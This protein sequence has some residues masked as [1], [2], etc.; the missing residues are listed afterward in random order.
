MIIIPSP[1]SLIPPTRARTGI[2]TK[3]SVLALREVG[4]AAAAAVALRTSVMEVVTAVMIQRQSQRWR[5]H[6]SAVVLRRRQ[7][8]RDREGR[9]QHADDRGS[10]SRLAGPSGVPPCSEGDARVS[11]LGTLATRVLAA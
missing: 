6:L 7:W 5:R 9:P 1:D 2:L 11:R 8:L 4:G 10:R 3:S